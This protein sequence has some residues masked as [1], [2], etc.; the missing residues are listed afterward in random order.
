ME[1]NILNNLKKY[2]NFLSDR[3]TRLVL[4]FDRH[5]YILTL[6]FILAWQSF[7]IIDAERLPDRF[8]VKGITGG[9]Y[10]NYFVYRSF[11]RFYKQ[12]GI[13][14]L[15][16]SDVF[17]DLEAYRPSEVRS[18]NIKKKYFLNEVAD[19]YRMGERG[20]LFI[21]LFDSMFRKNH[22]E[23]KYTYFNVFIFVLA[24]WLATVVLWKN[25]F[26]IFSILLLFFH[27]SNE[28]QLIET[29]SGYNIF[30]INSS[31]SLILFALNFY[32]FKRNELS[33]GIKNKLALIISGIIVGT[34]SHIR[35]DHQTWLVPLVFFIGLAKC[36]DGHKGKIKLVITLL[37]PFF[38][39]KYALHFYFE[40]KYIESRE[41]IIA[42]GGT[43]FS[44][45]IH[46]SHLFWHPIF[47]GLGDYGNDKG[48][49]W[50]DLVAYNYALPFLKKIHGDDFD[51]PYPHLSGKELTPYHIGY[52]MKKF[53]DKDQF[54]PVKLEDF[55]DYH[56]IIKDK[57]IKDIKEDPWWYF[58][59]L[60]K[61]L[62]YIFSSKNGVFLN[63]GE[64]RIYFVASYFSL[65]GILALIVSFIRRDHFF[66]KLLIYSTCAYL[67][68]FIVYSQ[69]G[70]YYLSYFPTVGFCYFLGIFLRLLKK[71]FKCE[72][73]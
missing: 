27:G 52:F 37:L 45:P 41:V 70:L 19:V 54:Y 69:A 55:D 21:L 50:D 39:S 33:F 35:S 5:I 60:L 16:S 46:R 58:K 56:K 4:F 32:L 18:T 66:L 25:N 23:V 10:H 44:G 51:S 29:F 7:N 49:V 61:R 48:Y 47:C 1:R 17:D 73:R 3:L 20:K 2:Y 68:S 38:L 9:G 63:I 57:I 43:P 22:L 72:Y 11:T 34:F 26:K 15:T 30:S 36:L 24:I 71:R 28:A 12:T 42:N 6:F 53:Y 31:L 65:I 8:G 14:P 67:S 59:I 13:F 64:F 62:K 40:K